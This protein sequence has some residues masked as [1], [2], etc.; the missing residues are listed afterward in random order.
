MGN[1]FY[2]LFKEVKTL[3]YNG[4]KVV[5]IVRQSDGK[6]LT[7]E[8]KWT[9]FI[10][11]TDGIS[12]ENFSKSGYIFNADGNG[13]KYN[14]NFDGSPFR[15]WYTR[16][17]DHAIG[18]EMPIFPVSALASDA[19]VR[20]RFVCGSVSKYM[21]PVSA[22]SGDRGL[23]EGTIEFWKDNGAIFYKLIEKKQYI[24]HNG[25]PQRYYPGAIPLTVNDVQQMVYSPKTIANFHYNTRNSYWA[26]VYLRLNGSYVEI[27]QKCD[28][29]GARSEFGAF[30]ILGYDVSK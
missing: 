15:L 14:Q 30:A 23:A 8:R 1:I 7:F 6:V 27:Q 28:W 16:H 13:N 21:A 5:K 2:G 11:F 22:T 18:E 10:S 25:T 17:F 9:P 3:A 19:R 4:K 20:M 24:A 29:H 26:N 12:K